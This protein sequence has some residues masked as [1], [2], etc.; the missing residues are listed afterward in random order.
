M[1]RDLFAE[2]GINPKEDGEPRDLLSGEDNNISSIQPQQQ[3]YLH[4]S[5]L[6]GRMLADI[7][8]G[9]AQA[10]QAIHNAPYNIQ[11]ALGMPGAELM[12][13]PINLDY[14]SMAGVQNP[15][16]L[17]KFVQG[18]VGAIPAA[19][20]SGGASIPAQMGIW[21]LS[22]AVQGE[23]HPLV[24]AALGSAAPLVLGTLG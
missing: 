23:S 22:G 20:L 3:A 2:R 6:Q 15:N 16:T 4:P 11:H 21:G 8:A 17:D 24:G 10:G 12:P 19:L 7:L 9:G 14:S 1:P 5:D 18:S 13:S